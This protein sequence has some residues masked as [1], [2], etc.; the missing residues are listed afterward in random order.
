MFS[1]PV[2]AGTYEGYRKITL[3]G[4]GEE[5]INLQGKSAV[6]TLS[7]FSGY[8]LILNGG[9]VVF[10]GTAQ[11]DKPRVGGWGKR[12]ILRIKNAEAITGHDAV[13]DAGAGTGWMP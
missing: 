12:A 3:S 13:I 5:R 6:V 7:D 11:S 10:T 1:V 4:A 2:Y 9:H 8:A